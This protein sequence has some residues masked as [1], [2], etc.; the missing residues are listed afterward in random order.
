MRILHIDTGMTVRG[1]QAQLMMLLRGLRTKGHDQTLACPPTSQLSKAA[2]AEGFQTLGMDRAYW[3][4]IKTIRPLARTHDIAAAHD[5]R[6]QTIS[7]LATAGKRITRV[8][9]R[10]VAFP[11]RNRLTHGLKYTRTCEI[12]IAS[13]QA[14]K[15]VMVRNGVP[16][17]HIEVIRGGIEFPE[18]LPPRDEARASMRAKWKLAPDDFVIG[19]LAAF[20][21]EK[22]QLD[23]L[24]ALSTLLPRHPEIRMILA[25]DGP[26]R[27]DPEIK[28]KALA[29]QAQLPGYIQPDAEFYSGLDLFLANSTSEALGLA[30][31]YAMAHEVPVIASNVGGLPEVVGNGGWLIPPS[32]PHALAQAIESAIDQTGE[33]LEAAKRARA[34][35]RHFSAAIT[36]DRTEA[37]YQ[38]LLSRRMQECGT[39]TRP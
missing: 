5:S 23:A 1:G 12:V 4:A 33:R 29:T 19:H 24:E 7:F 20:T 38:R 2:S 36:V 37:L 10:L 31:L 28:A 6:A 16:G 14:V 35:A 17:G 27:N 32:D 3:T 30:P 21:P 39:G 9:D 15:D 26:L 18:T 8:A 34:H 25:G 13:S 11:P 22:G